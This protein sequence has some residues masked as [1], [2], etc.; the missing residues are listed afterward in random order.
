MSNRPSAPDAPF[1]P[2]S[3]SIAKFMRVRM[4]SS[5]RSAPNSGEYPSSG[6]SALVSQ[7]V[8]LALA[9]YVVV[10]SLGANR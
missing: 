2:V 7:C 5:S 8:P 1:A 10:S 6:W 3:T 4:L 9:T